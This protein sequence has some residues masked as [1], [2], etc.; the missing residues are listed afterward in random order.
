[1]Y[2]R[3]SAAAVIVYDITKQVRPSV[4]FLS[5]LNP[6]LGPEVELK[7]QEYLY[8]SPCS[9][10]WGLYASVVCVDLDGGIQLP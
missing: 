10:Q 5:V 1:M 9:H 3:G 4:P 7:P 6:L 2:Y 8:V